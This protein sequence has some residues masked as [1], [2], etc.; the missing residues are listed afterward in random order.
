MFCNFKRSCSEK[1]TVQNRRNPKHQ[2]L[3]RIPQ[4]KPVFSAPV[5][6]T[7]M[8]ELIIQEPYAKHFFTGRSWVRKGQIEIYY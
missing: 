2:Q 8:H 1:K 6:Q 5:E 4:W 3:C 7:H